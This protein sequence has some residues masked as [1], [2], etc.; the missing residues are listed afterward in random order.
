MEAAIEDEVEKAL[1]DQKTVPQAVA[2]AQAKLSELVR[3][4]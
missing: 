1:L 2:D 3:K 4:R